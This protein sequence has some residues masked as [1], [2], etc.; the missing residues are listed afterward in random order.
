MERGEPSWQT[1]STSPMSM[2]SSSDA[3]ATSALSS[4]A[5]Q[6]LLGIQPMLLGEAAVMRG[7]VLL[8]ERA[9]RDG[10]SP[11]PPGGGC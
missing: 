5:L 1:R 3:V 10:A 9:P 6:T 8:A 2:P 4:P 11:A 7:D